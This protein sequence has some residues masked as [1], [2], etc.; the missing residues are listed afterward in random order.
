MVLCLPFKW[1]V[2]KIEVPDTTFRPLLRKKVGGISSNIPHLIQKVAP[3]MRV[4]ECT[5]MPQAMCGKWMLTRRG[6]PTKLHL[7][8]RKGE[9][10]KLLAHA[11]L[12]KQ[13]EVIIGATVEK[14]YQVGEF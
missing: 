7:G 13:S 1:I 3:R 14:F 8:L 9:E 6:I 4:F 5:C 11:W 12:S 2:P 10:D